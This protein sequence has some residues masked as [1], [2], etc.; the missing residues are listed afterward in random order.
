MAGNPLTAVAV[1]L[2]AANAGLAL[3]LLFRHDAR[4]A[5]ACWTLALFFTPVYV[6]FSVQSLTLTLLDIATIVSLAACGP[7]AK[8]R[9]S[10]IDTL[11]VSAFLLIFIGTFFGAVPG[12]VQYSVL[13][14]LLPYA[15][16]RV[17]LARVGLEWVAVC[18][19]VAAVIAA[20]LA[21]I[22]FLSGTNYFVLIPGV[23]G[24]MWTNLQYRGG[25]LRAE[26][27]FG[28]SISLGSSLAIS[29]AFLLATP[30]RLWVK[31]LAFVVVTT[32][33]IMTFSRIG[34]VGILLVIAF[35]VLFL[36]QYIRPAHRVAVSIVTLAAAAI[37]LP[38]IY[39]V[40]DD[41][42]EEAAGSAEYRADL[43]PLMRE[44]VYI[45]ISPGREVSADGVDYFGGFR[46]ID[47]ALI[48]TGL[49]HGMLPL[50]LFVLMLVICAWVVV[51][52]RGNP[53]AVAVLSQ[54][55]ALATVALI[56]QYA[57]FL[58]FVAGVAVA[59]YSGHSSR[60][61]PARTPG[62]EARSILEVP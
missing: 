52:G 20:A 35:S 50:L 1:L 44:M 34:L 21:I 37:V 30:W 40:F 29:S 13:S 58:W 49:R 23:D 36:G 54:V 10:V 17:A 32:G 15:W 8:L 39:S 18:I 38:L 28:H 2:I 5:V 51:S 61:Q 33:V 59:A 6:S 57:S 7:G 47:S 43:L 56:T 27:A 45:G 9:W 4:W 3:W 62:T 16:G 60:T 12:H 24:R 42:G 48:L 55:P 41:A 11:V 25:L 31:L 26:G 22:E 14:W 46:S 19:S 53:A